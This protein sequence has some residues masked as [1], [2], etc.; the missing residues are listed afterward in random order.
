MSTWDGGRRLHRHLVLNP[1]QADTVYVCIQF[2]LCLIAREKKNGWHSMNVFSS[3]NFLKNVKHRVSPENSSFFHCQNIN[4]L[5]VSRRHGNS[6]Q[7]HCT[8][9]VM[10]ERIWK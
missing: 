7:L 6:T 8:P 9:T 1:P 4:Y 3:A 5:S 10:P 2:M